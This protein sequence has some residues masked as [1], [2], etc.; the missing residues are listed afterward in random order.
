MAYSIMNV[1]SCQHFFMPFSEMLQDRQNADHRTSVGTSLCTFTNEPG[2]R[3][4]SSE[5]HYR[6]RRGQIDRAL[7][8]IH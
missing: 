5:A 3:V 1:L 8:S 6:L 4:S 2:N 7:R